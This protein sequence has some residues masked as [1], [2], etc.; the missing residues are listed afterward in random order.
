MAM[1]QGYR[2]VVVGFL[3]NFVARFTADGSG[4]VNSDSSD[5]LTVIAPQ[6]NQ[7]LY[8][9]RITIRSS[10]TAFGAF[11]LYANSSDIAQLREYTA[12]GPSNVAVEDPPVVFAPNEAPLPR[13]SG[14]DASAS[15]TVILTGRYV[16]RTIINI[17]PN[18]TEG[19]PAPDPL[20]RG[21]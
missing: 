15:T 17:D 5:V 7:Y 16:V 18:A 10:S 12:T 9:D 3:D 8:I 1:I 13:W 2:E 4:N 19:I 14:L 6:G 11:F 21:D 20:R